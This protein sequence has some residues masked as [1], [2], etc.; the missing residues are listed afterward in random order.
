MCGKGLDVNVQHAPLTRDATL[1]CSQHTSQMWLSSHDVDVQRD[2]DGHYAPA[3]QHLA[4][5]WLGAQE[6]NSLQSASV[7]VGLQVPVGQS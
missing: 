7:T 5:G 1:R 4:R 6:L 2:L 3:L